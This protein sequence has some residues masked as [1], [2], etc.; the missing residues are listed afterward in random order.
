MYIVELNEIGYRPA[1]RAVLKSLSWN[2][3]DRERIGLVGPNG[4]GKS[5]LMNIIAG[6]V[7]AD[8][9][10]LSKKRDL[11]VGYLHQD[12]NLPP[13][14]TLIEAAMV[15]PPALE[16]VEDEL[17]RI[18]SQLA[19]RAVYGDEGKLAR[20][21]AQ[22]AEATKQLVNATPSRTNRSMCGVSTCGKP[23]ALTVS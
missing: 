9:G 18:E 19:D 5:S 22:E 15:R 8:D 12:V 2:I 4:A 14:T 23:S 17:A 1:G 16:E 10:F 6:E 13:G 7:E 20:A 11:R 21:L 3:G